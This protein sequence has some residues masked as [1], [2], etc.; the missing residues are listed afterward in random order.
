ME[1]LIKLFIF[2][3]VFVI[4]INIF[5]PKS[6]CPEHFNSKSQNFVYTNFNDVANQMEYGDDEIDS[7]PL[8]SSDVMGPSSQYGV[9]QNSGVDVMD[10]RGFKW[11]APSTDPLIDVITNSYD[12]TELKNKFNRMYMLDPKG[13]VAKYDITYNTISP[14]CCPAQ[15]APPFKLTSKGKTNC[16]YAQKYVANN[17]S[18]QNF[19]DGSGCTCMTPDQ[20]KFYGNRGSNTE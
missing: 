9:T 3:L 11:T 7:I 20:A 14:N 16:D 8:K 13:S 19:N 6:N 5:D 15:Y 2:I 18:G 1:Q 17:Y 10:N 12:S 4:F